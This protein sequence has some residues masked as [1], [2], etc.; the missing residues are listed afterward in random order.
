MAAETIK[1]TLKEVLF[2]VSIITGFAFLC[3]FIPGTGAY[4]NF[5]FNSYWEYVLGID[6]FLTIAFM[7]F[8]WIFRN[9]Q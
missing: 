9:N 1:Q 5:P 3:S 8:R 7:V 6:A 4:D 2:A